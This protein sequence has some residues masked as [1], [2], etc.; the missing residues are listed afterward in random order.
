MTA[1]IAA[2]IGVT[3][4]IAVTVMAAIIDDAAARFVSA[5]PYI[6]PL[7]FNKSLND[8]DECLNP[9]EHLCVSLM[10]HEPLP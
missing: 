3:A 1:P 5:T 4:T 7:V 8:F 10:C 2:P 6:L 9:I